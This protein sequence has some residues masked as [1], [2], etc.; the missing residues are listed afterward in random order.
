MKTNKLLISPE[1]NPLTTHRT[2]VSALVFAS[3][4][5]TAFL[6]L[7]SLVAKEK[8]QDSDVLIKQLVQSGIKQNQIFKYRSSVYALVIMGDKGKVS[9]DIAT[10]DATKRGGY[11]TRIDDKREFQFLLD[12]FVP[13]L[14]DI[15]KRQLFGWACVGAKKKQGQYYWTDG[16]KI[17]LRKLGLKELENADLKDTRF[18]KMTFYKTLE[19]YVDMQGSRPSAYILEFDR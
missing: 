1:L 2:P 11:V 15:K 13:L 9:L 10:E 4:V 16:K 17:N 18:L 12:N 6:Y 8:E 5:F 7:P 14:K 3:V 19:A